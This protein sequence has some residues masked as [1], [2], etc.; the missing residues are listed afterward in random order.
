MTAFGIVETLKEVQMLGDFQTD[1]RMVQIDCKIEVLNADKREFRYS[2]HWG[3][4]SKFD[5][6]GG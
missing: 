3:F 4:V 6:Q 2:G 1:E 5:S